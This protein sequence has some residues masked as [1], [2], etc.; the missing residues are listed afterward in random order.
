MTKHNRWYD[1]D[2]FL[3]EALELLSLSSEETQGEAA[4]FVLNLQDQVAADVI[5]RIYATVTKCKDVGNRWYDKDTV[6][7][8]AMEL[9]RVAKPS[10]QRIAAKKILKALS[11]DSFDGI[12]SDF[13]KE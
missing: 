1:N 8:K 12:E 7:L 3:K 6:M 11:Q 2:P 4:D 5:E 13:S 10:V 9:L